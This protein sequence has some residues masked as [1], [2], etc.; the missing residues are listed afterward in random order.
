MDSVTQFVLGASIG[1]ACLGKRHGLRKAVLTGGLLGTLPDLDVFWNYGGPLENFVFHRSATHSLVLQTIITPLLA[2]S[3]WRVFKKPLDGRFTFYLVIWLCLITHAL[4]DAVTIYGTQLFWPITNHPF[5]IGS[6]FIIDP[7]Y[8]L[9]LLFVVVWALIRPTWTKAYTKALTVSFC[10]STLYL[11]WS[12]FAQDWMKNRAIEHFASRNIPTDQVL[13]LPLP[14]STLA[15]KAIAVQGDTYT[16]LYLPLTKTDDAPIFYR[17]KRWPRNLT[18]AQLGGYPAHEILRAFTKGY[19]SLTQATD[20]KLVQADLRMGLTPNYVFR[21]QLQDGAN[22]NDGVKNLAER[23]AS[24]RSQD[25]DLPWL[26]KMMAGEITP[27]PAENA[28]IFP[29]HQIAQT[30]PQYNCAKTG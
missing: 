30:Q 1:A 13:V 7:L 2:E 22:P 8:T 20:N 19:Y 3:L 25:G 6:V 9:P 23:V 12:V 16:N 11:G 17:H 27:R 5:G 14:F 24:R 15:W 10:L 26:F 18:C 21:F 28:N 29:Q 4:L